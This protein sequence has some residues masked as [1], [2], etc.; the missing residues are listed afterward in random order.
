MTNP[1]ES[2]D[3]KETSP[4]KLLMQGRLLAGLSQEQ[5][6]KELYLTIAKV[7]ALELDD[8]AHVGPDTFVRGYIRAYSNILKV[9]ASKILAVYEQCLKAQSLQSSALAVPPVVVNSS[10][11]TWKFLAAITAFFIVMWLISIWFMDTPVETRYL[12]PS[13][14]TPPMGASPSALVVASSEQNSSSSDEQMPVASSTLPALGANTNA[15]GLSE[16][17]SST[18]A[19]LAA[20]AATVSASAP[21]SVA[22]ALANKNSLDEIKFVFRSECWLEVSDSRGDVLA[23]ELQAP[24]SKLNLIGRAPFDVKLGNASAVAIQINGKKVDVNP[25]AG[26]K[27]LTLKVDK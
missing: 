1:A 7:S 25:V 17:I 5:V 11:K 4:G 26:S 18:A 12:L 2:Q 23:T 20:V 15:V 21:S 10:K 8:F 9:D 19:T 3:N 6:A 22:P 24:G 27:V 14:D 16:N 13:V